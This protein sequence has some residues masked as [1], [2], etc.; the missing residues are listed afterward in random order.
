MLDISPSD[1]SVYV[2]GEGTCSEVMHVD[3]EVPKSPMAN[4]GNRMRCKSGPG[5]A[6]LAMLDP[7]NMTLG[8]A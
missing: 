7:P 3:V 1:N 5:L 4:H 8:W 6:N 2:A